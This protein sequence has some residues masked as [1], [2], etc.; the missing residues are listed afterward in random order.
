MSKPEPFKA[1]FDHLH[2][3]DE[4][5]DTASDALQVAEL[6]QRRCRKDIWAAIEASA[7]VQTDTLDLR[8]HVARLETLVLELTAKLNGGHT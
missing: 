2:H 4:E 6:A 8:E 7:D 5:V 3:A 1:L